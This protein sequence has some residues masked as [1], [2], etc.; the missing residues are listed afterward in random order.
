MNLEAKTTNSDLLT[1]LKQTRETAGDQVLYYVVWEKWKMKWNKNK[2]F[3]KFQFSMM[4]KIVYIFYVYTYFR[5]SCVKRKVRLKSK[6]REE[7]KVE[8]LFVVVE[9]SVYVMELMD[10]IYESDSS[11]PLYR[12]YEGTSVKIHYVI[13]PTETILAQR[14]EL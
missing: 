6:Q 5:I 3:H 10:S 9:L 1:F 11:D 13:F 4:E 8:L 2:K 14:I 12:E 7:Q